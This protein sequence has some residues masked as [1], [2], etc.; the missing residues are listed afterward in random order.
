MIILMN[1]S[2]TLDF[3]QKAAISKHSIPELKEDADHLVKEIRKLSTAEFSKLMKTSNKL[4]DLN[5]ERYANWQTDMKKANAKQ[6]LLA[7]RGDIYAGM[8]VDDYKIKDFNF[9]QKHMRILSGLYGILRPLDLI[10][11]YRLEMATKLATTRG[12]NIYD[13]WGTKLNEILKALL[14]QEKSGT[15]V[16]LCSMEYFKVIKPNQLDVRVIT[17]AFKEFRD[18]NYRFITLYAKKARG[19]MCNY[20]IHNQLK[21]VKDLKS[22]DVEGYRFNEEISSDDQ[23]VFTRGE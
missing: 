9:A 11:P 4:T 14:K 16:N 5:L 8:E 10:Q 6:A 15:L 19:M 23:W 21:G 3:K 20:I 17:P 12:K 1:S 7:F 2:K 13:F 18:G 22:F